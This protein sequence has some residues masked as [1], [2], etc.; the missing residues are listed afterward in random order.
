MT[1]ATRRRISALPG[2]AIVGLALI[3]GIG[4]IAY[5]GPLFTPDPYALS[6]LDRIRPPSQQ[7]W[8]G[9]DALGRDVAARLVVGARTTLQ[10]VTLAVGLAVLIGIPLGI[11]AGYFGGALDALIMRSMD[12]LFAFPPVLLAIVIAAILGPGMTNAMIA[13]GVVYVPQMARVARAPVLSL[14]N[15]EFVEAA[16]ALGANH[17]RR[18]LRHILPNSIAPIL[19]QISLCLSRA[20]LA[21]AALSFLGLGAQPPIPS[22]G[23]ML[24]DGR[25][26]LEIAPWLSIAPGVFIATA[27]MGFNLLGDGLRDMLDPRISK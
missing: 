5:I 22:W 4:L 19:V 11:L 3:L 21:E 7:H 16:T 8:L 2:V 26:I 10:V 12:V 9:T 17:G 24:N 6:G 15:V 1:R 25:I 14:R 18:M 13:I 20:V 23:G 27:S